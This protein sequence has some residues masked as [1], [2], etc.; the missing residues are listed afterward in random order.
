M[1]RARL[2]LT[3]EKTPFSLGTPS[4]PK[5]SKPK[6]LLAFAASLAVT[7]STR[8][9][10]ATGAARL[11]AE[12]NIAK[13]IVATRTARAIGSESRMDCVA[14]TVVYRPASRGPP[15]FQPSRA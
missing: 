3:G 4:A 14:C 10:S 12:D 15:S 6:Q 9:E 11:H 2:A 13:S 8:G 7:T 1:A 5:T